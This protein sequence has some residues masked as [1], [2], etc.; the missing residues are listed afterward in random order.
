MLLDEHD[1]AAHAII[2][3]L[4]RVLDAACAR[5]SSQAR[6]DDDA[7]GDERALHWNHRSRRSRH[8]PARRDTRLSFL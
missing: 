8:V 2:E 7:R 1:A 4:R 3:W 5:A 6:K